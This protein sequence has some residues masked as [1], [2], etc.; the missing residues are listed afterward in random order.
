MKRSLVAFLCSLTLAALDPPAATAGEAEAALTAADAAL[1]AATTPEQIASFFAQD[2]AFMGAS[3]GLLE[4]QAAIRKHLG[5][6]AKL[7]GIGKDAK[8]TK[9]ELSTAGDLGFALGQ[10]N[11]SLQVDGGKTMTVPGRYLRVWK[12][13]DGGWKVTAAFVNYIPGAGK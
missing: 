4:G 6:V 7:A 2:A 12:K 10:V 8:T 5:D 3:S 9:V 13:Q 1:N 11:V